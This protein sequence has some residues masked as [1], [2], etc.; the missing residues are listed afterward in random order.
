MEDDA[1]DGPDHVDAHR[2]IAL[3][4]SPYTQKASVDSTPYTTCSMLHTMELI[5][6]IE[7]MSQFDSSAQPMWA[8]FQGTPNLTT[9]SAITPEVSLTEKNPVGTRGD[10]LSSNFDFSKED[11]INE[12]AFNR[13]IWSAV[14]GESSVMPA[15]VH[16]AFVKSL[17]HKKDKDGDDDND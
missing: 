3:A 14:K 11:L 9:Y 4:V 8:A 2:T 6:G 12:V 13:V 1:Q 7:P 15:P 17:K 10:K 5:L 16:A